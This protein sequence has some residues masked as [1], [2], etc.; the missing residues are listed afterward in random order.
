MNR[1]VKQ[2][3]VAAVTCMLALAVGAIAW[4]MQIP[5][6][7]LGRLPHRPLGPVILMAVPAAFATILVLSARH[8]AARIPGISEDNTVHVQSTLVFLF[9]LVTACQA[10]MAFLYVGAILPDRDTFVRAAGVLS[11]VGMAVRGNFVGKLSP[12]GL[13]DPPDPAVW[14]RMARR[15]GWLLVAIGITLAACA[16]LLPLLPLFLVF[17][18]AAAGLVAVSFA[19]H[20]TL[21]PR[22]LP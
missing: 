3:L 1:Y 2:V 10:W 9:V 11:G 14:G 8:L 18:V 21:N 20:R 5:A 12:P 16:I 15:T 22:R 19:H 13:Q 17:M 6:A 7:D 4:R